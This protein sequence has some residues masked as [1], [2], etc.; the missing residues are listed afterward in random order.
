MQIKDA[1]V[2]SSQLEAVVDR[3][4]CVKL[5]QIQKRNSQDCI[6][7]RWC[8]F[9]VVGEISNPRESSSGNPYTIWKLIDLHE[10]V[11]SLYLFSNA[12]RDT[13]GDAMVG[14]LV[15]LV[16]PRTRKPNERFFISVDS[17]EQIRILGK[18]KDF[19]YCA[20]KKK[21]RLRWLITMVF[22]FLLLQSLI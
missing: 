22:E 13:K 18:A 14:S 20:A 17:A 4:A 6:P 16:S 15:C 9:A 2:S 5:D 3:N 12:Y 1:L 8:T 10:C 19:G 11:V 7:K 21:V